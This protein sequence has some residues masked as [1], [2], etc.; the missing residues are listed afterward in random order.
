MVSTYSETGT[1][2][3]LEALDHALRHN[4]DYHQVRTHIIRLDSACGEWRRLW[5]QAASGSN[6]RQEFAEQTMKENV[7]NLTNNDLQFL[8]GL[9]SEYILDINRQRQQ[10]GKLK[11]TLATTEGII[12]TQTDS[13]LHMIEEAQ[14]LR[15]RLL[16]LKEWA[17]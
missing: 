9:V 2:E 13:Y 5:K 16:R 17:F 10:A 11:D 14:Q 7:M 3:A 1:Q 6:D 4:F 12:D 8:I 15:L